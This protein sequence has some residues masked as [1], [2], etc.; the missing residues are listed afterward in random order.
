MSNTSQIALNADLST[1]VMRLS[2]PDSK[3]DFADPVHRAM[4]QKTY[5]N[6]GIIIVDNAL[7]EALVESLR[8]GLSDK[9]RKFKHKF[10]EGIPHSKPLLDAIAQT[11]TEITRIARELFGYDLLGKADSSFRPMISANEPIHFDSYHVEHGLT[12]LMSIFNFARDDR[13]WE[14]GPNFVE[15]VTV[16]RAETAEVLKD[17]PPGIPASQ[18]LRVAA[19]KGYGPLSDPNLVHKLRFAPN[20]VWF[21]NPKIISHKLVYG[22]GAAINTWM[23]AEPVCKCQAC[24]LKQ[25]GISMPTGPIHAEA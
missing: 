13:L 5:E 9:S 7:D 24:L 3:A 8:E 2:Y 21:S 18:P 25:A 16:R 23:V 19:Q 12:P 11:T 20:A 10:N 15:L 6:P 22:R 1:P 4:V 17:I 14:V